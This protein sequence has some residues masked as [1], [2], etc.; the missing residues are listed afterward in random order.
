LPADI[1]GA[2]AVCLK[3]G[4][5]GK[6]GTHLYPDD[7]WALGELYVGPY[8]HFEPE[9][10]FVLEDAVGVCGYVLGALDSAA[11]YHRMETE[12][13]PALRARHPDPQGPVE[14]LT[15]TQQLYREFHHYQPYFPLEF[16]PYPAHA[17]IDL[18]PRAQGHG[19]G[20]RMMEHL[21]RTLAVQGAPG[22][23]L[24]LSVVNVRAYGFYQKLG[25][26]E[27]ART[28]TSTDGVIFMGRRLPV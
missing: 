1:P 9:R 17:H 4:D 27:L 10:A 25:F 3:T 8:I 22:V 5:S 15:S 7:P 6:D 20:R 16:A 2:Y 18:L 23:H 19:E 24:G 28:G 26:A 14:S 12:W 13:L 21:M 11:F